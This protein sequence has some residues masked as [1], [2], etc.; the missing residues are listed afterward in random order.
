LI[1]PVITGGDYGYERVNVDSGGDDDFLRVWIERM[2][3]ARREC[4]EVGG[5]P[6]NLLD[7]GHE[8]V[9]APSFDGPERIRVA[10]SNRRDEPAT[11][12]LGHDLSTSNPRVIELFAN[13]RCTAK[14]ADLSS[15]EPMAGDTAG[16][17]SAVGG[18]VWA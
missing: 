9:L 18:A 11:I 17:S 7:S 15:R 16:C 13:H 2:L 6:W 8:H 5:G 14:R 12:D 1:R 4:P 10:M 3:R